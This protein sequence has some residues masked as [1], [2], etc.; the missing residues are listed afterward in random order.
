M[1]RINDKEHDFLSLRI[2]KLKDE[3]KALED[4]NDKL[5]KKIQ[6]YSEKINKLNNI[7]I[8]MNNY[9]SNSFK[10]KSIKKR[11]FLFNSANNLYNLSINRKELSHRADIFKNNKKLDLNFD[12]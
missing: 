2:I 6:Q 3:I 4:H 7:L 10:I 8:R 11:K 1:S 5:Y 9:N 12:I